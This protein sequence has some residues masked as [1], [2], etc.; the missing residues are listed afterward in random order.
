MSGPSEVYNT[1]SLRLRNGVAK[2]LHRNN[3]AFC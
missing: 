1:R 2:T 3:A